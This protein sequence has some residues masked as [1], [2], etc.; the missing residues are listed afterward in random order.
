MRPIKKYIVPLTCSPFRYTP[1]SSSQATKRGSVCGSVA[2]FREFSII[3]L[4]TEE[5]HFSSKSRSA[6]ADS[7]LMISISFGL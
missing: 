6:L 3:A 7:S 2:I 4:D 5:H 1:F